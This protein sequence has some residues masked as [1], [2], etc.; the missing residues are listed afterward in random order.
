MEKAFHGSPEY[1]SI[2]D[3]VLN[4]KGDYNGLYIE[5]NLENNHEGNEHRKT[6]KMLEL[7]EIYHHCSGERFIVHNR[8]FTREDIANYKYSPPKGRNI[9]DCARDVALI[10]K[11]AL[12]FY[13]EY[14][15]G[16]EDN[17]GVYGYNTKSLI[18]RQL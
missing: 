3:E 8:D 9:D 15:A 13:K 6:S 10:Y 1:R 4:G 16:K 17:V 11:H 5:H 18:N 2:L 14:T 7:V 12:H